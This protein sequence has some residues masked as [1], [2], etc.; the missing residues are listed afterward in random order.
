MTVRTKAMNKVIERHR[1]VFRISSYI[2]V[3][4]SGSLTFTDWYQVIG[5]VG[6]DKSG[7]GSRV[8]SNLRLIP[9]PLKELTFLKLRISSHYTFCADFAIVVYLPDNFLKPSCPC[10]HIG[11]TKVREEGGLGEGG[12]GEGETQ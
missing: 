3:L 7:T 11:I 2:K 9:R 10:E 6:L 8:E 4:A 5:K 12:G 1:G